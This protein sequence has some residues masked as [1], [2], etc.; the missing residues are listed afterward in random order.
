MVLTKSRHRARPAGLE[1]ATCGLEIQVALLLSLAKWHLTTQPD[2][3]ITEGSRSALALAGVTL[4]GIQGARCRSAFFSG[5]VALPR[6]CCRHASNLSGVRQWASSRPSH[7]DTRLQQN[8][9]ITIWTEL[10]GRHCRSNHLPRSQLT[11][12]RGS[13]PECRGRP[14][15]SATRIPLMRASV[16]RFGQTTRARSAF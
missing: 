9:C 11:A 15:V 2:G 3:P 7:R 5:T 13:Y 14:A 10:A 12:A 16:R 4:T 1:R 8:L 6:L